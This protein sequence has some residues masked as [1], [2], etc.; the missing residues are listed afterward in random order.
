[1]ATRNVRFDFEYSETILLSRTHAVPATLVNPNPK[2][3]ETL[4]YAQLFVDTICP[5]MLKHRQECFAS[6]DKTCGVC[7]SEPATTVKMMPV[8][9]LH[10]VGDP[11][12]WFNVVPSCNRA[13]QCQLPGARNPA[14]AALM[15]GQ[16]REE[17]REIGVKWGPD[18]YR[19]WMPC[20]VCA[21]DVATKKCS[22][23][24]G[25]AYCGKEHQKEHWSAHKTEC[26]AHAE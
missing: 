8:S 6:A 23:C 2:A 22:R 19:T 13:G 14:A 18:K 1:M 9:D 3:M 7:H 11:S 12:V 15:L 21:R 5:V 26:V 17:C 24:M 4:D 16:A 25:V 20:A 10:E